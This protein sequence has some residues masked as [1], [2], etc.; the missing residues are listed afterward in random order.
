MFTEDQS[1]STNIVQDI[2]NCLNMRWGNGIWVAITS[3]GIYTS[4]DATNFT[5]TYE[6]TAYIFQGLRFFPQNSGTFVALAGDRYLLSND[7][8]T[9]TP[10]RFN[11]G[12]SF[13]TMNGNTVNANCAFDVQ[14]M[15]YDGTTFV[16]IGTYVIDQTNGVFEGL[17]MNGNDGVDW[18]VQDT[19]TVSTNFGP[20]FQAV[21]YAGTKFFAMGQFSGYI[22]TSPDGVTWTQITGGALTGSFDNFYDVLYNGTT[23]VILASN[24]NIY[25]ATDPAGSWTLVNLGSDNWVAGTVVGTT[26]WI[27]GDASSTMNS[28]DGITWNPVNVLSTRA[29][30][31]I[32]HNNATTIAVAGAQAIQ[33]STDGGTVWNNVRLFGL[34]NGGWIAGANQPGAVVAVVFG[35]GTYGMILSNDQGYTWRGPYLNTAT[36]IN[37]ITYSSSL[38]T[39]V[40]VGDGGTIYASGGGTVWTP[41]TSGTIQNLRNVRWLN[42]THYVAVGENGTILTST[43]GGTWVSQTTPGGVSTITFRDV[44]WSGSVYVAVG[45][46]G[47]ILTSP[48]LVTWTQQTSITG[49]PQLNGVAWDGT[50]FVTVGGSPTALSTSSNGVTWVDQDVTDMNYLKE[51]YYDGTNL[52]IGGFGILAW[53]NDHGVTWTHINNGYNSSAVYGGFV[54]DG[55]GS[56]ILCSPSTDIP[57]YSSNNGVKWFYTANR[58]AYTAAFDNTTYYVFGNGTFQTTNDITLTN[59]LS[60]P[61]LLAGNLGINDAIFVAGPK[62]VAVGNN[63]LILTS[64]DAVTWIWNRWAGASRTLS[65]SNLNAILWDGSQFVVVGDHGT[66]LTSPEGNTWTQQSDP[67]GATRNL[68]FIA[69]GGGRYCTIANNGLTGIIYMT[70][71]VTTS[72]TTANLPGQDGTH[73]IAGNGLN[74]DG[75]NFVISCQKQVSSPFTVTGIILYTQNGSAFSTSPE[76]TEVTDPRYTITLNGLSVAIGNGGFIMSNETPSEIAVTNPWTVAQFVGAIPFGFASFKVKA[77]GTHLLGFGRSSYNTVMVMNR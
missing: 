14:D 20:F 3:T 75:T 77:V 22:A 26:F 16:A 60:P 55:S 59:G 57:I 52:I 34:T 61:Q 62:Y 38:N 8:V 30:T 15:A 48:D 51:V 65:P 28:T 43:N 63:G 64:N 4:S 74:W 39:Y 6:N 13:T 18:T 41:A 9:W 54:G 45:D 10:I 53:S 27:V 72:W 1:L 19:T 49:S 7:G 44:S 23:Y 76:F 50:K 42:S 70:T 32:A 21:A 58:R 67:T 36:A 66:L 24:G 40:V 25:Y 29:M 35:N 56:G 46:S 33:Y 11:G 37:G 17:I 47:T 69:F 5:L 2:P 68:D 73:H 31:G 12:A 71:D